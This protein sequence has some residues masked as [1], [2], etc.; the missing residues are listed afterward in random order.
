MKIHR[1]C[2]AATV[3]VAALAVAAPAASAD[4]EVDRVEKSAVDVGHDVSVFHL[5][6]DRVSVG[7]GH[8]SVFHKVID[9]VHVG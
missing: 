4:V 3:A 2:A 8:V 5:K 9:K 7:H 1:F 6:I